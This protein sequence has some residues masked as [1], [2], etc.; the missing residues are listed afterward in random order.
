M[1]VRRPHRRRAAPVTQS[2]NERAVCAFVCVWSVYSERD[3]THS[4]STTCARKDLQIAL[5]RGV[6]GACFR[7][8]RR[9]IHGPTF[10]FVRSLVTHQAPC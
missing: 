1:H 9:L 7:Q 8:Q 6:V 10:S 5:G 3:I 4:L 2:V